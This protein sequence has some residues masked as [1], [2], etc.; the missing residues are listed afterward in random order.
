[1]GLGTEGELGQVGVG[2]ALTGSGNWNNH[3]NPPPPA[4]RS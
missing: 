1:M 3:F 4:A 2:S